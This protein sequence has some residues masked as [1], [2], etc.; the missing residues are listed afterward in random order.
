MVC[1]LPSPAVLAEYTQNMII[2][3][4]ISMTVELELRRFLS[5]HRT[6]QNRRLMD[7]KT[8]KKTFIWFTMAS[9]LRLSFCLWG[10]SFA[11]L[12]T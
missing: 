5:S 3:P 9:I 7:V 10:R 6:S 8:R 12:V 4:T 2:P 1:P 11:S